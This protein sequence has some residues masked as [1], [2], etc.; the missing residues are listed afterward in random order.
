MATHVVTGIIYG[1]IAVYSFNRAIQPEEDK[2]EIENNLKSLISLIPKISNDRNYLE[3]IDEEYR[4]E[5]DKLKINFHA[6]FIPEIKPTTFDEVVQSLST[7][8]KALSHDNN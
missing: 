4:N 8:P 3:Q 2:L 6:D 1:N 7:I 5:I